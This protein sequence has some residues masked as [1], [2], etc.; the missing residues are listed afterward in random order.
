MCFFCRY[1]NCY[2]SVLLRVKVR[3]ITVNDEIRLDFHM[4]FLLPRSVVPAV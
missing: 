1:V 3:D 2:T 4:S